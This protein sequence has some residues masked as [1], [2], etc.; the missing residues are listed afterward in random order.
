M[1]RAI[2]KLARFAYQLASK[3]ASLVNTYYA[4]PLGFLVSVLADEL[5]GRVKTM[6][7]YRV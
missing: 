4:K 6:V 5:L 7:R 3:T 1:H 2:D